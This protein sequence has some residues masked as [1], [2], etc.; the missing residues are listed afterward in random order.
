VEFCNSMTKEL[1][2]HWLKSDRYF[3]FKPHTL[4]TG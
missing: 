3:D 1:P 4:H 2:A